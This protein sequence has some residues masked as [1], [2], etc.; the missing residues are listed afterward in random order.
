M[1]EG[2]GASLVNEAIA[3]AAFVAATFTVTVAV[4]LVKLVSP[5]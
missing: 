3:L 2:S 4:E 5:E 1:R